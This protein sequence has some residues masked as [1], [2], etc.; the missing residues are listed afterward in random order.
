M[1]RV[2]LEQALRQATIMR[3]MMRD[4]QSAPLSTRT[5]PT[6]SRLPYLTTFLRYMRCARLRDSAKL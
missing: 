3:M 2:R 1:A 5:I 6:Q 4:L